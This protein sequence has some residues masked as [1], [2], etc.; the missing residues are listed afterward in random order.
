M[1][2]SEKEIAEAARQIIDFSD[3]FNIWLFYG[4]MG[5]GKT[6]LINSICKEYEVEDMVS[7]PSFAIINEYLNA[8]GNYIYH[9]DFYRIKNEAEAMTL[10]LE[11]YFDSG[12]ICMIEWPSKIPNLLPDKYLKITLHITSNISR[13][14]IIDKYG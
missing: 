14:I 8:R 5:A 12:S 11:E 9:F 3:N 13:Q 10:G 4:E 1:I 2:R 7:S 6:T